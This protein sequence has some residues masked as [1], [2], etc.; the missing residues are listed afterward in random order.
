M[1]K[2]ERGFTLIELLVVIAIIGV[3]SS[4]VLASVNTARDKSKDAKIKAQLAGLRNAAE[5]YHD[6]TGAYNST[7]DVIDND[8]SAA[9]SLFTDTSSSQAA[10]FVD[11]ANYPAGVTIIC[12]A[13]YPNDSYV[14]EANLISAPNIYWCVDSKGS[15]YQTGVALVDGIYQCTP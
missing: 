11:P 7:G 9:N 6:N 4:I 1:I 8:C 14:V 10:S 2:G 3:L 15:S 5:I 13:D 12:N